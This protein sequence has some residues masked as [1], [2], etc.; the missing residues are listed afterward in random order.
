MRIRFLGT[1]AAE[2]PPSLWCECDLCRRDRAAAGREIRRRCGYLID[3]D[4]LVD[5]GPDLFA[6][7]LLFGI[8]WEKLRRI[9]VTHFSRNGKATHRELVD[10]FAPHGVEV[11]YDGLEIVL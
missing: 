1:A 9:L 3:D 5:P 10:F 11:A 4:T 6:Q 2:A 7:S 8:R